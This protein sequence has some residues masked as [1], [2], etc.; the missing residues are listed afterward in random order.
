MRS[1]PLHFRIFNIDVFIPTSG[2]IGLLLISYFAFPVSM[3]LLAAD[4]LSIQVF[5]LSL[6]HGLAIYFTIFV[7]ELGHVIAARKRKY[8]VKGIVLH[9]FGGH[10]SFLGK[11][12]RPGDQFW[13]AISGPIFT[14]FVSAL[15]YLLMQ[16]STGVFSSLSSWLFWSS[17]AITL[18]NLLPGVPLDGGGILASIVWKISKNEIRGQRFA[19]YGGYFVA[20]IWMLSPFLYGNFLGWKVTELDI[21]FSAMIGVWLFSSARLTVKISKLEEEHSHNFREMHDLK[22]KD[23]ARRAVAV[24][25]NVSLASALE[26]MHNESAGSILVSSEK[27]IVGIVREEFLN[28][29]DRSILDSAVSNFAMKTSPNE[30]LNFEEDILHNQRISSFAITGQWIAVDNEGAIY[31]VLHHSDIS[32]KVNP[33]V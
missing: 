12:R 30:W 22:V 26:I 21:F 8:E 33:S 28:K 24:D 16:V 11:Y 18:V 19:G 7:H 31:G 27:E 1:N 15:A 17:L 32:A 9:L 5:V 3:S 2:F 4:N 14:L 23:L 10:T 20:V 25:K 29:D 6:A 13:T